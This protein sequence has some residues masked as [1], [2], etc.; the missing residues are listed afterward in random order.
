MLLE[1]QRL[2]QRTR[3]DLEMLREVGYCAGIENYS[4]HLEPEAGWFITLD[5]MDYLPSEYLLVIDESHM[6]IHKSVACTMATDLVR[7][8][9]CSTVFA[10]LPL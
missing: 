4:R 10:C 8:F 3:Y 6:T 7:A 2:E 1:Y 9:W 5:V